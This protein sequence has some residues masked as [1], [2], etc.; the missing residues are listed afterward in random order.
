MPASPRQHWQKADRNLD[1]AKRLK[2]PDL[3][4]V[5]WTIVAAFY[6]SVHYIEEYLVSKGTG[7]EG[8]AER[9]GEIDNSRDLRPIRGTYRSLFDECWRVRYDPFATLSTGDADI[10][11]KDA[12]R[13][14]DHLKALLKY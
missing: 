9:R 1:F 10:A 2:P 4:S 5:E 12:E 3:V 11:I 14:R 13:I 6:A 7:S 8:H